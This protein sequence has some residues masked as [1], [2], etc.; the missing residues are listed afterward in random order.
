MQQIIT[1]DM[2]SAIKSSLCTVVDNS[3][4]PLYI[5]IYIYLYILYYLMVDIIID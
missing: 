5:Y 2:T 1:V 3:G 4:I